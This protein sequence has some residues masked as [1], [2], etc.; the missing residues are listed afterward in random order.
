MAPQFRGNLGDAE[1]HGDNRAHRRLVAKPQDGRS[2][3]EREE[4]AAD[5]G[6]SHRL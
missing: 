2:S 1:E 6:S 3:R 5:A 4:L